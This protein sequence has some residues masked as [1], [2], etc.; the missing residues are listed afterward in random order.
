M[1]ARRWR[2]VA[3][4]GLLVLL[5]LAFWVGRKT[6]PAVT[7]TQTVTEPIKADPSIPDSQQTRL[8]AHNL[9]LRKGPHFRVYVRWIRG[10]M[11]RTERDRVPDLDVPESFVLEI[12][13]AWW[14]PSSRILRSF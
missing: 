7:V 13:K 6:T 4:L 10:R 1:D 9:L 14:M 12:E 3:V 11:V 2:V 5:L 8:W